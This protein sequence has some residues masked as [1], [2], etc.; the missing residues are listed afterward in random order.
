MDEYTFTIKVKTS[1]S[2]HHTESELEDYILFLL[3][4][5]PGISQENPFWDDDNLSD[6]EQITI[7]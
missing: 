2:K 1:F 3:G 5:G 4:Y 7:L 6:I